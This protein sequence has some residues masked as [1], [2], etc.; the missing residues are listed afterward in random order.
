MRCKSGFLVLGEAPL[1]S[2]NNLVGM[3]RL[4]LF[5]TLKTLL[6]LWALY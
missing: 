1:A 5:F 2:M 3:A 6:L 4:Q